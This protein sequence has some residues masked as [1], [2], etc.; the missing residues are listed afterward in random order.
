MSSSVF[1]SPKAKL[2]ISGLKV[3]KKQV[4]RIDHSFLSGLVMSLISVWSRCFK[5]NNVVIKELINTFPNWAF[6]ASVK[7]AKG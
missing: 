4:K 7:A 3:V 6:S 5:L 1:Y 2:A